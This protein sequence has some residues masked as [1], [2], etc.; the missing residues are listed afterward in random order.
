[1]SDSWSSIRDDTGSRG[2]VVRG[3]IAGLVGAT[4]LAVWFLIIDGLAGRP[5][6]T[7][8]FLARLLLGGELIELAFG[9]LALYTV[10]HYA[11]FLVVGIGVAWLRDRMEFVPSIPLGA[12]LGF[13]L[14]DLLFYGSLWVTGVDV[15]GYLG[16]PEVLAGNVLAG[17]SLMGTLSLLSPRPAT[18]WGEV[19]AEHT[20]IREGLVV[21]LIGAVAVAVWFLVMD[22]VAG[23]LLFTPA[24]L[25]S[26]IFHGATGVA[27]VRL[28]AI[29]VLAYTSFH[30]AAFLVTGLLA[31][32][33]VAFAEDRHAYVLLGA[34]LLFVTFETFFIGLITIVAQ[35]LLDVIPWWSIAVANLVAAGGMGY[36]LWRRHP[37]LVA[38]LSEPELER[39]VEAS[40]R[41]ESPARVE[42]VSPVDPGST[43][44]GRGMR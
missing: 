41:D 44:A 13:L 40:E 23:R 43:G 12:V 19:L 14:F 38:A 4:V 6:H 7:P 29:T 37:K 21:G 24:A 10:V 25:G 36:Y 32:A 33:I 2:M 34:A 9:Q 15:V 42:P 26:V 20:T 28:D 11:A 3:L 18:S 17:I 31:A 8:A 35:W 5:F 27:D 39:R 1:M 22:A 16:W 30:L